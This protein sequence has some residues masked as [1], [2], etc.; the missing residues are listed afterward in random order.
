MSVQ[1]AY[2]YWGGLIHGEGDRLSSDSHCLSRIRDDRENSSEQVVEKV[3]LVPVKKPSSQSSML[4]LM[5][6]CN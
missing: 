1:R 6:G 4:S 5:V 2:S 3:T